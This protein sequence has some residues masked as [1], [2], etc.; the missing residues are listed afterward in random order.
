MER[1]ELTGEL[2]REYDWLCPSSNINRAHRI[3]G[4]VAV[5]IG[6]TTHRVLDSTGIVHCVPSV[7]QLGCVLTW[8]PKDA[9]NPVQF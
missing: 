4:P 8:K 9:A 7:G 5:W 1:K 3:Y 6:S 2:W